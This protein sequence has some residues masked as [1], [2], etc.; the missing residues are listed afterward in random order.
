M[1][2]AMHTCM[3][4]LQNNQVPVLKTRVDNMGENAEFV[5]STEG[6][7]VLKESGS[8]VCCG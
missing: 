3:Y 4:K 7:G 6:A 8:I 2:A 1:M 5:F